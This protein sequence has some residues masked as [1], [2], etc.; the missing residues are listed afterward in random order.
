VLQGVDVVAAHGDKD[1]QERLDAVRDFKLGQCT[2][3]ILCMW[4]MPGPGMAHR[5]HAPVSP[6][7][8]ACS[9][10]SMSLMVAARAQVQ[11]CFWDG[12]VGPAGCKFGCSCASALVAER[13]CRCCCCMG[14]S[15]RVV[16]SRRCAVIA[17]SPVMWCAVLDCRQV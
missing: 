3:C 11:C 17:V 2:D 5:T 7:L 9:S 10:A 1:Q 13:D 6:A 8:A 4:A 12:Q 15:F 16:R 14:Y